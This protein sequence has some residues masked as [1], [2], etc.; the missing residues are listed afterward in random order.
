MQKIFKYSKITH[1]CFKKFEI[2]QK[3][4]IILK[5][6]EV[7]LLVLDW[8]FYLNLT[9]SLVGIVFFIYSSIIIK[10]IRELFPGTNIIKRWSR[11]QV[12][13]IF[14]LIGYVFNIIALFLE[15]SE[16]IMIMTAMVY[17][18]GGFFVFYIIN[19]S[20]KT[21]KLVVLDS[22]PKKEN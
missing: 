8:T 11:I 18:F 14:F 4:I 6:I 17:I 2:H 19:L 16:L 10:R 9:C 1:F 5:E 21:Y 13:I 20:Y 12:L 15:L 7:I 3:Y 22:K